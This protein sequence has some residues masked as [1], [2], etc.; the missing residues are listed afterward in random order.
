[1]TST[2]Y[3]AYDENDKCIL[4]ASSLNELGAKLVDLDTL[5][6]LD[7]DR[8]VNYVLQY[9]VDDGT[10][11]TVTPEQLQALNRRVFSIVDARKS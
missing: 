10:E 8:E 7:R 9:N 1:M 11:Y 4:D 3:E 2:I 6:L 5:G